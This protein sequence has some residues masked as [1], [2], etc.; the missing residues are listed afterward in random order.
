MTALATSTDVEAVLGRTLTEAED[1]KVSSALDRASAVVRAE[2]GRFFDD[3]T[4]TVRRFVRKGRA[5]LD[6]PDTITAIYLIGCD[7]ATSSLTG[8]TLRGDTVYGLG[9]DGTIEVEYVTAGTIPADIVGVTAAMAA[10]DLTT[11]TPTGA[12]SYTLTRGPFSESATFDVP[13]ESITL[14]P[15]ESRILARYRLRSG[16]IVVL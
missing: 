11:Q 2:T 15:S 9:G 12:T 1:A 14:S 3:A 6:D 13:T 4:H 16:A 10:R 5:L 8:Y 7:G